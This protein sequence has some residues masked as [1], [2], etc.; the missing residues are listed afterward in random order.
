M[1]E[2]RIIHICTL[3]TSP[4]RRSIDGTNRAMFVFPLIVDQRHHR[5]MA[6]FRSRRRASSDLS[7]LVPSSMTC[8]FKRTFRSRRAGRTRARSRGGAAAAAGVLHTRPAAARRWRCRSRRARGR[9]PTSAR[10]AS[11]GGGRCGARWR[12]WTSGVGRAP[13]ACG[14]GQRGMTSR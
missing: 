6:S 8:A 11:S 14:G 10:A 5:G 1:T 9:R 3:R 12:K 13:A 4:A 2:G 7:H